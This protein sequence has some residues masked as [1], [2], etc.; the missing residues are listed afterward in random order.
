MKDEKILSE[1]LMTDD[2]LENVVG[3]VAGTP[4][5]VVKE[6]RESSIEILQKIKQKHPEL[7][8]IN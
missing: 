3:G 8:N 1:E 5:E 6:A 7:V 2:D 4:A